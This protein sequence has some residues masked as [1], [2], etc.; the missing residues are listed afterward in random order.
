MLFQTRAVRERGK[1]YVNYEAKNSYQR[2]W[3]MDNIYIWAHHR[4]HLSFLSHVPGSD[5]S[6]LK[7]RTTKH[8]GG[9]NQHNIKLDT[10]GKHCPG[11]LCN[12]V[13]R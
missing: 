8:K 13:Q 12:W 11:R 2:V 5:F 1:E 6:T 9:I 7:L 4:N 10:C 3:I